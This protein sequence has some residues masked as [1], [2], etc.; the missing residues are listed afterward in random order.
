MAEA[1]PA[2]T[3]VCPEQCVH[4][5]VSRRTSSIV[6]YRRGVCIPLFTFSTEQT[7]EI[8]QYLGEGLD[9]LA[10]IHTQVHTRPPLPSKATVLC[11]QLAL[12][13]KRLLSF[14][15]MSSTTA[16]IFLSLVGHL[17]TLC[18]PA[19]FLFLCSVAVLSETKLQ[20]GDG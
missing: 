10:F 19:G 17:L 12:I 2:L 18:L 7:H 6:S 9:V 5:S 14:S 8:C 4:R 16:Y 15:D 13:R 11:K 1:L 20:S 3:P